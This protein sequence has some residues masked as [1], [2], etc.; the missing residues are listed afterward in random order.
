MFM[1]SKKHL[2]AALLS[3]FI[4][5]SAFS[6]CLSKISDGSDEIA[7]ESLIVAYEVEQDWTDNSFDPIALADQFSDETG[8]DVSLYSVDSE[9]AMIEA[10]RFG[11]ADIAIMDGASAWMAWRQYGLEAMAADETEGRM[12]YNSHAWVRADSE[13]ATAHLDGDPLTDPMELLVGKTACHTG[14]FDSVGMLLPIGFLLGLGYANV[15]GDPNELDSL[16]LTITDYFSED[17]IIPASGTPYYGYSGALRCLSDGTGDVAFLKGSTVEKYCADDD[18]ERMEW[19]LRSSEY[20]LLPTFGRSPS[21]TVMYNPKHLSNQTA[22]EISNVL[23]SASDNE[24][25]QQFFERI[26]NTPQI[27]KTS[28]SEHLGEYSKLVYNVPGLKLFFEDPSLDKIE[29]NLSE[30]R[31]GI[32]SI[33]AQNKT[34]SDFQHLEGFLL[35]RLDVT[36]RVILFESRLQVIENLSSGDIDFGLMDAASAWLGWKEFGLS[37]IAS[38]QNI[39]ES[40][41]STAHA[42]IK[43]DGEIYEAYSDDYAGGP[44]QH[45]SDKSPCFPAKLDLANT[46]VPLGFLIGQGYYFPDD[47]GSLEWHLGSFFSNNHSLPSP[48]S[49]YYGQKGAIRCLSEGKGDIAFVEGGMLASFCGNSDEFEN[50]EWCWDMDQ[51]SILPSFTDLPSTS[52]L[53]NPESLDVI[54]RTAILNSF[55]ELNNEIFLQNYTTLGREFTGCY[56]ISIHK[57]DSE[58]SME[59]C[60]S[61][62]LSGLFNSSAVSRTNSQRHL[63]EFSE[64]IRHVPS[65][66]MLE[67]FLQPDQ[68]G[69]DHRDS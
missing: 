56:D 61:E 35:E 20:L 4:T 64:T 3:V 28:S 45:F 40:S 46:L 59:S 49:T 30:I 32:D 65:N 10:L 15:L 21:N 23:I 9:E 18:S 57:V 54:T 48:D 24:E 47:Q 2:K 53:Y 69:T 68:G 29:L 41:H 37:V 63:G 5:L 6:G 43:Q 13:I 17:T 19:C 1:Q 58:S 66:V 36:T 11:H 38:L 39:D 55:M 52:I 33:S 42:I 25:L 12:Y 34:N 31:I 8:L 44:F 60:G 7:S 16:M 67:Y 26:F 22:N 50:E 14:W 27:A 51:Y 62:I